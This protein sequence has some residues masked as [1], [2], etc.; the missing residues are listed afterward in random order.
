MK[1]FCISMLLLLLSHV[2]FAQAPITG[3]LVKIVLGNSES[4]AATVSRILELSAGPDINVEEN[5]EN[6]DGARKETA[7][8][9]TNTSID[10]TGYP[11]VLYLI[12]DADGIRYFC[13]QYARH[14]SNLHAGKWLIGGAVTLKIHAD[15][16]EIRSSDGNKAETRILKKELIQPR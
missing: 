10:D 3:K 7:Q 1:K 2:V 16:A 13:R 8:S 11:N 14:T 5:R 4:N 15:N 12:I 9:S 6:T